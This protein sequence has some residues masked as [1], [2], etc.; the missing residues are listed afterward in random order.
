[1]MKD[2]WAGFIIDGSE[3]YI[4]RIQQQPWYW[5]YSLTAMKAFITRDN[6]ADLLERSRFGLE[7]G[8][9][10]V[11]I[12]GVDFFIL[13]ALETWRP[14][15][16]IV[17]YN[18]LYGSERTVSVPYDATFNRLEKHYS[19]LYWGASLRA[20][21]VLLAGR[22]YRLAGVNS[23]GSNAFFVRA[24]KA[25]SNLPAPTLEEAFR[26]VSFRDSRDARGKLDFRADD[27]LGPISHMP[28]VDT[29]SGEVIKVADL[30]RNLSALRG[31]R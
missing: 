14:W 8:I 20:F 7:P 18:G 28:L 1:M 10:S 25:H 3:E 27:R 4:R 19:G 6:V 21:D 30:D 31:A 2:N 12:D 24:D 29:V 17:E 15:M 11:D 13:Q 22:G 9:L 16:V 5:K 23:V 26:P